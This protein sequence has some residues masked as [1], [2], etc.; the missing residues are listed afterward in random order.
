MM[1]NNPPPSDAAPLEPQL[2]SQKFRTVA[3]LLLF[4]HLFALAIAL[5]SNPRDG[6]A[7]PLL[8]RLGSVR[9]LN[10]YLQTLWM[11]LG[12]DYFH[13]YGNNE[14]VA[15]ISSDHAAEIELKLADGSTRTIVS[16]DPQL[17]GYR[18]MRYQNLWNSAGSTVGTT[19]AESLLPALIAERLLRENEATMATIR[20][21]RH[22]PVTVDRASS[23]AAR[24]DANDI[25][26]FRTVYTGVGQLRNDQFTFQ[27]LESAGDSAP[28]AGAPVSTAAPP[29]QAPAVPLPGVPARGTSR[30]PFPVNK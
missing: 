22:V 11:D 1:N 21:K 30:T 28:A 2:P 8:F 14:F 9:F 17:P 13:T 29:A 5:V 4:I 7:S 10:A 20:I 18:A 24:R 3:S 27:K 15:S 25:A 26:S 19:G 12:Y 6:M 23:S 16:P